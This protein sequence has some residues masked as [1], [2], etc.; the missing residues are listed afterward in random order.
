MLPRFR[1]RVE[2]ERLRA[3]LFHNHLLENTHIFPYIIALCCLRTSAVMHGT[4]KQQNDLNNSRRLPVEA[5]IGACRY[6]THTRRYIFDAQGA[7]V[8]SSE[9]PFSVLLCPNG[10]AGVRGAS[11][12]ISFSRGPY[13]ARLSIWC[14]LLSLT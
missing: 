2:K 12:A 7:W 3:S 6:M 10:P 9:V 1:H 14:T 5:P 11:P 8:T 4:S 13:R